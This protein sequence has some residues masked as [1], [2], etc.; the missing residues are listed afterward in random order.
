MLD[1]YI[2]YMNNESLGKVDNAWLVLADQSP[3]KA[4]VNFI[5]ITI[6]FII[7]NIINITIR[8]KNV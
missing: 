5:I 1:F 3:L 4:L 2:E 6:I 7:I 8:I